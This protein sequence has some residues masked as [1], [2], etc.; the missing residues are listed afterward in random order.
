[1]LRRLSHMRGLVVQ[2]LPAMTLTFSW[3]HAI[4]MLLPMLPTFWSIWDIWN[5]SFPQPEKKAIWLVIV[6]FL[7]VI[8]GIVYIFTGRKQAIPKI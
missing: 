7:P 1:M 4:L 2:E 8:G 5:H 3:W 6:V